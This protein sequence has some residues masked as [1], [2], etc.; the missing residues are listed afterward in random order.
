MPRTNQKREGQFFDL[1]TLMTGVRDPHYVRVRGD[2]LFGLVD[3]DLLLVDRA[4]TNPRVGD[5]FC[6]G[7]TGD[8]SVA[9]YSDD[10]DVE[11]WGTAVALIRQFPKKTKRQKAGKPSHDNGPQ[12]DSLRKALAKLERAPEN[13]A[14][15]F[16]LETEI[17]HLERE[18]GADEWP[19]VIGGT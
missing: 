18:T 12:L 2:H 7:P 4:R 6:W 10:R 16:K 9:L 5:Y 8:L 19:D 17:Y 14:E 15:R 1:T 11:V 13:E 3:G